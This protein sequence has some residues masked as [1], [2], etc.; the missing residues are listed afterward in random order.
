MR[1][2]FADKRL[3]RMYTHGEGADQYPAGLTDVYLRRIRHIESANDERDLRV[4]KSVH[5][6]RLKGKQWVGKDSMRLNKQWR[7]ILSIENDQQ[8][9]FVQIHEINN[10]YGD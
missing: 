7:L 1:V 10:H 5:Y 3:E 2:R 6:E 9:K 4:P 8:G